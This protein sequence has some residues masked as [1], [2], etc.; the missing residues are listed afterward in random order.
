LQWL[1]DRVLQASPSYDAVAI[2]DADSLVDPGFLAAMDDHLSGGDRAL[3]GQHV[4]GNPEDSLLAAM[5]AADM[6]L[7][8]RLRNQSRRNLGL[9][10]RLMGDGMVFE[11]PMLRSISWRGESLTEDREYGYELLLQGIRVVYVPEAESYG[12]AASRWTQAGPQRLRWYQGLVTMQERLAGRLVVEAVRSRSVAMLDGALELLMPSF[13]FLAAASVVNLV[14]V[15][16]L[17][18]LLPAV[19]RPLGLAGSALLVLAWVLYPPV[20]LI[21]DGAPLWAFRALLL[22]PAY[23]AWRLWISLLVRA[24][25]EQIG[26]IRTQ[27]REEVDPVN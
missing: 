17:G 15:V 3:Q 1:L 10:C 24:R 27:R 7:N 12:Q 16:G 18:A 11:A 14:L 6:R 23:V 5:A 26:W 19:Q 22:G 8:N 2:F 20:G 25:G 13:S 21:I 9:S 4:I